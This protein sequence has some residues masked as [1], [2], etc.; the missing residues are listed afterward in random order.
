[1]PALGLGETVEAFEHP[2]RLHHPHAVVVFVAQRRVEVEVP[3][4]VRGH[5]I[6]AQRLLRPLRQVPGQGERRLQRRALGDQAV[7]EPHAQRFVAAN[8]APGEDHVQRVAVTDQPRQAHRTAIHQRHAPA[9]AEHAEHRILGRDAQIAPQRQF[10]AT[11]HGVALDRRQ[12]RLRQQ[13]ARDAERPVAVFNDAVAAP[14]RD[15]LEIG[16]GAKRPIA[17]GQD[18]DAQVLVAI[19]APKRRR[20]LLRRGEVDGVAN[21]G[22]VDSH[23]RDGARGGEIDVAHGRTSTEQIVELLNC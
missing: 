18:R 13:H 12:D 20:Q 15:R 1:V 17:A 2:T 9:A 19:K 14:L 21:I 8:A 10:Q 6:A 4:L 3:L 7:G 22:A 16:A 5:P 11:R 23:N